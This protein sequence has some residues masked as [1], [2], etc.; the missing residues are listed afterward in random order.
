MRFMPHTDDDVRSM[1]DAI[2]AGSIEDLIAHVPA[3]LRASAG[4][5]LAPGMS[6]QDV[7]A[8]VTALA[9]QNRAADFISFLGGGYYNHYVPAVVRAV[10]SRAEFATSYTPYQ[11]EASQGTT[12][13][14]FEFQTLI[15]QLTG[16][17][18][19]NAS[20]YDGA[21]AAA[22][23]VLMAHRIAPKRSVVALS[24]ALWPDYRATI[25]TYL[26]ALKEIEIIEIPFDATSGQ[27]DLAALQNVA[28]V[29][30]LC[31]VAGYPNAFGI[32]EPL[33]EI[34][35]LAHQAGALAI[36]ATAEGLALGLLKAPGD[37]GIDIAVGE[38]Q[39]FGL[40]L[41][42]GGPGLG[43][44]AARAAHMRQMPGRLVG[45]TRDADGNRAFTLTLA[46]RE[47]HIRR[48]RATS[49]ICTNHSLCALAATV[50]LSL[51]GRRGLRELAE[52]NVELAHRTL[53]ELNAAN[54]APRFNGPFFNEFVVKIPRVARA[55]EAAE[56][57]GIL[58]GL[59]MATDYPELGDAMLIAVTEM[60]RA[61]DIARLGEV[62]AGAVREA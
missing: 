49:N 40:P 55:L 33:G 15:T 61:S 48:E 52:R 31:V 41:Q 27:I 44:M 22:E 3:N 53:D 4:I 51:M 9:N 42:F 29:N 47:Q 23:A 62:L 39:S 56:T 6:E 26:S 28:S 7:A 18:V 46:T 17:E 38:G 43:F 30:L 45:Q 12:Q 60:N 35:Q 8:E 19:A 10:T 34:G 1:L 50:Y 54:I 37:L 5:A 59:P 16:L 2:G 58:A 13:A 36:A 11:A 25:R 21:S 24:R 14:I 57:R 20:M 32:V